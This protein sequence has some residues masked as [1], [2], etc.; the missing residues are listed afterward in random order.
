LST[1]IPNP[2][3]YIAILRGINVGGH[4]AIKMEQLRV[5]FTA[6]HCTHIQTYIQSGNVVFKHETTDV[7]HLEDS[8]SSAI[9][10]AF[11][12]EV[13]VLILSLFDWNKAIKNNPYILDVA[14]DPIHLHVTFLAQEPEASWLVILSS[15]TENGADKFTLIGRTIYVHCPNGYGNTKLNNTFFEKQLNV[16]ATTR[17]LKTVLKLQELGNT[18]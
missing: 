8:I 7:R 10:T 16:S 18:T 12:F 15:K 2:T 6:L 17:N 13:P 5:I 1:I 3:S 14:I 11:G 4:R 9:L